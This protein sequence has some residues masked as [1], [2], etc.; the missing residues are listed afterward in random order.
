[1]RSGATNY[2]AG[3]MLGPQRAGKEF[4]AFER[5]MDF[6]GGGVSYI[7]RE[8]EGLSYSAGIFV[9]DRG[10]PTAT[11]YFSTTRPDSAVKLVN[12]LLEVFTSD[13][14]IPTWVVREGAK[15][16]RSAYIRQTE[17]ADGWASLLGRALLYEGDAT[18]AARRSDMM[19]RL[20]FSDL[21][22]SARDYS[23]NI[24]WA[25]V[26]DTTLMSREQFGKKAGLSHR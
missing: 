3:T 22:R 21:R 20:S 15:A 4:A 12:R 8:R 17:T 26:G 5:A 25:F 18:A 7:I 6:L 1:M 16:Y 2:V 14:S 13:V 10:A 9:T 11:I 23:K 24:Q 19:S